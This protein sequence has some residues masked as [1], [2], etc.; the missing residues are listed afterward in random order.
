MP[1]VAPR[2]SYGLWGLMCAGLFIAQPVI[3]DE[4]GSS[5]WLPGQF[6]S[7]AA[8]PVEPGW[9]LPL[10]FYHTDVNAEAGKEF[11]VG[12]FITAGLHAK[13]DLL[14]AV[15]TYTFAEP[16]LGGQA[17]IS[18]AGIY[19]RMAVDV[20]ATL[21]GPHGDTLS[22]DDN[23]ALTSVGDLFPSASLRWADGSNNYMIYSMF[24]VPVGSYEDGRLA[25]IGINHW[26]AD[27]GAHTPI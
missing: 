24:N 8:T 20:N 9:S 3:A 16:V 13:A 2:M 18:V 17:A 5:F 14:I 1:N 12:G 7:L 22:L 4:G 6:G 26:A 21:A 11:E 15:P 23:D 10:V 27:V 19:G 25:N